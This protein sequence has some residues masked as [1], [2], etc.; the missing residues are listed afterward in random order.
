MRAGLVAPHWLGGLLLLALTALLWLMRGAELKSPAWQ[1]LRCLW[2]SWRF[3]D[4]IGK[5]PELSARVSG[6]DWRPVLLAQRRKAWSLLFDAQHNL[7]LYYGS[8]LERLLEELDGKQREQLPSQVSYTLVQRLV[9]S[10]LGAASSAGYQFRLSD[11]DSGEVW[12][13]SETHEARAR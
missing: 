13:E 2:P 11:G 4:A 8:L 3:F 5:L 9:E 6:G 10:R 1:L 7:E 12:F